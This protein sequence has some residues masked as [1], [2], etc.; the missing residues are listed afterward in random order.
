MSSTVDNRIV[1]MQFDNAQFES[2]VKTTL[3]TLE[4][5]KEKM[6]FDEATE[7]LK[8]LEKATNTIDLNGL[9]NA[10][11][12]VTDRFSVF[13]EFIHRKMQDILDGVVSSVKNTLNSVTFEPM[14]KGWDKYEQKLASVQ[15]I[16]SALRD[17]SEGTIEYVSEQVE[18][19]NW[20]TDET[21]YSFTDMINTI[22]KFTSNGISLAD[23]VSAL[24]GVS[25]AAAAAGANVSSAS[26]AME[27]FAK[28]I[29][30]GYMSL[31]T[32]SFIKTAHMDTKQFKEQL[33]ETAAAMGTLV[34]TSDGLYKTLKGEEVSFN[35]FEAQLTKAKWLTKEVL[36]ETL[37]NYGDFAVALEAAM[38]EMSDDAT[39]T[40][41]LGFIDRFIEGEDVAAEAA[42]VLGI[43]TDKAVEALT[44][45]SSEQFKVGRNAF[46]AA[47]EAKTFTDA[48]K[49][50][51]DATSTGWMKTW[52]LIFG[53]YEES[54]K[55]W[56]DL[57]NDL[58][59][60]FMPGINARNKLLTDWHAEEGPGSYADFVQGL[61][62]IF[63]GFA[64]LADRVR[65][66]FNKLIPPATVQDIK[67]LVIAFKSMTDGFLGWATGV[68]KV[69]DEVNDTFDGI[70][71]K[72]EGTAEVVT[73]T[74][75]LI[76]E[77]AHKVWRG[78]FGNG[79]ETRR[80][81]LE[82]LGYSFELV[83]NRVNELLGSS[84][85]YDVT[86]KK[87]V[88]TEEKLADVE[89][90][91]AEA[92]GEHAVEAA[93]VAESAEAAEEA[94][95]NHVSVLGKLIG[96]LG[97]IS[98]AIGII[99]STVG[100]LFN[101]V[102]A[103][104]FTYLIPKVLEG[105]LDLL[106]GVATKITEL[107]QQLDANNAF[108][109]FFRGIYDW[110]VKTKDMFEEAFDIVKESEALQTFMQHM[111]D[112]VD[113]MS[114]IGSSALSGV[115]NFFETLF[116]TANAASGGNP[117]AT[118]TIFIIDNINKFIEWIG[119]AMTTLKTMFVNFF[120]F[121]GGLDWNTIVAAF[122]PILGGLQQFWNFAKDIWAI[123]ENQLKMTNHVFRAFKTFDNPLGGTLFAL[124]MGKDGMKQYNT[125]NRAVSFV[126]NEVSQTVTVFDKIKMAIGSFVEKIKGYASTVKTAFQPVID[127]FQPVIDI[128]KKIMEKVSV[129][130]S[131]ITFKDIQTLIVLIGQIVLIFGMFK[132]LSAA[133][134]FVL[135]AS[136]IL[137][138]VK[139]AVER[140]SKGISYMFKS[141]GGA[142]EAARDYLK[143]KTATSVI[144][145]L[146]A[147]IGVMA[148]AV[149]MLS[150]IPQNDLVKA[151]I[152]VGAMAAVSI[153]M[154]WALGK[155]GSL[156]TLGVGAAAIFIGALAA[157]IAV[158]V[159][160][161]KKIEELTRNGKDAER[162]FGGLIGILAIVAIF[163]ATMETWSKS[164]TPQQALAMTTTMISLY[165]FAS[166]V[167]KL[168]AALKEIADMKP[169]SLGPALL[170]L[171]GVVVLLGALAWA[172]SKLTFGAGAGLIGVVLAIRLFLTTLKSIDK[173]NLDD[174]KGTIGKLV[175][176]MLAMLGLAW[177]ASKAGT[178]SVGFAA[179]IA[180][181]AL[182]MKS[183]SDLI[184]VLDTVPTS[185]VEK[186]VIVIV[187][188][189]GMVSILAN[190][191]SK[192]PTV[193][194]GGKTAGLG[195]TLF[196]LAFALI[197]VAAAL[198][199][200]S[201][202]PAGSLVLATACISVIIGMIAV[203]AKLSSGVQK[204]HIAVFGVA[205]LL[206]VLTGL[207]WVV[208][209][210]P[211]ENAIVAC[212]GVSAVLLSLGLM[213]RNVSSY[214]PMSQ[215]AKAKAIIVGMAAILV[216]VA[217]SIGALA[218]FFDADEIA[219]IALGM[220]FLITSLGVAFRMIQTEHIDPKKLLP[221][222]LEITM[223]MAAI[224]GVI[225]LVSQYTTGLEA[226]EIAAALSIGMLSVAGSMALIGLIPPTVFTKATLTVA[227]I[228]AVLAAIVGALMY[229]GSQVG[230]GNK[231]KS[232]IEGMKQLTEAFEIAGNMIG[233]FLGSIVG[234]F[235]F[236]VAVEAEA[237]AK[238]LVKFVNAF[239]EID[240]TGHVFDKIESVGTC[241]SA[242]SAAS[243]GDINID[244]LSTNLV[245][246]GTAVGGFVDAVKDI[247][248]D[249][250]KQAI[251]DAFELM[252]ELG[253]MLQKD[254]F[255]NSGMLGK[256]FGEHSWSTVSDG[257]A[258]F[259]KA[260]TQF[261][262]SV[263]S[264]VV[265]KDRIKIATELGQGLAE[266]L[267]T[268]PEPSILEHLFGVDSW[269]AISGGL[270]EF[271]NALKDFCTVTAGI[272]QY[273]GNMDDIKTIV[274]AI[275]AMRNE[276]TAG[277][278]E[279]TL[280][281]KI[282]DNE[283]SWADIAT[284]LS[285]FGIA[286]S[287]F[288]L[289]TAGIEQYAGNMEGIKTIVSAIIDMKQY[290]DDDG[291]TWLER[292]YSGKSGLD[293]DDIG[294]GLGTFGESIAAFI[295]SLNGVNA[296]NAIPIVNSIK[297]LF[298]ATN[299]LFASGFEARYFS[300]L[301]SYL[302][303]FA[304]SMVNFQNNMGIVSTYDVDKVTYI[305]GQIS[306]ICGL[307]D[308]PSVIKTIGE[309]VKTFG[310][311]IRD[312]YDNLA[313]VTDQ[314]TVFGMI[315][316]DIKNLTEALNGMDFTVF[317]QL[318]SNLVSNVVNGMLYQTGAGADEFGGYSAG[319]SV[320]PLT[321]A[322]QTL[323]DNLH[324][325]VEQNL[326]PFK[327]DGKKFITATSEGVSADTSK[328][329]LNNAAW[330]TIKAC[331][332]FLTNGDHSAIEEFRK[333]GVQMVEGLAEGLRDK[334]AVAD[335]VSAATDLAGAVIKAAREAADSHSPS[336]KMISLGHDMDGGL[337]VGIRGMMKDVEAV[338]SELGNVACNSV[339]A[340][341]SHMSNE[342]GMGLLNDEYPSITPV[343]DLSQTYSG[344][345]DLSRALGSSALSTAANI[346]VDIK[347]DIQDLVYIG[348]KLLSAI[349][350]GNDLYLDENVLVGRINRRLGQI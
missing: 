116:A 44:S 60:I 118:F 24:M 75:E 185:A 151:G 243:S 276:L 34:K 93:A 260:M 41:V 178:A 219:A 335:A 107:K 139:E 65:K 242:L 6:N 169:E 318:G 141:I 223:V 69:K 273:A 190:A 117:V 56:T 319:A 10:M 20:Y 55:M 336:R 275:I 179:T 349:Q 119:P 180:A 316:E 333:L 261:G 340:A 63:D 302:D 122:Q 251:S 73:M 111:S 234:G 188:L 137:V 131:G 269:Q 91:V 292:W 300:S 348:N 326:N 68:E 96:I 45:L 29:G 209:I 239:A 247:N 274:S 283:T 317:M 61:T 338:G 237:T 224:G 167:V 21:S 133:S 215:L 168:V 194:K 252:D 155:L 245:G 211:I 136:K 22:S 5:L 238:E 9:N 35:N 32:W 293:W 135:E 312:L 23:S 161:L 278:D 17:T 220:T 88:K 229:A 89:G 299:E 67:N 248:V 150:S 347:D 19:L 294:N 163:V 240:D 307:F 303:S 206:L 90:E 98:S 130:V 38:A 329:T 25:S 113:H 189:I 183:I 101:Y 253:T 26:H 207:L 271:G 184:V 3:K 148:A 210:M 103:P 157:T 304:A 144:W 134:V 154:V 280:L 334:V 97:G 332:E 82:K 106:Y 186:G 78:D 42:E 195:G 171:V 198:L 58:Y 84:F 108:E 104:I 14:S 289:N 330:E 166:S 325:Y 51:Q 121:L 160:S 213:L 287:G 218:Y 182:V 230:D 249:G 86:E 296:S 203:F 205:A 192:M 74:A 174:V 225:A 246:M 71:D 187:A 81:A 7:S 129:L 343:L 100:A 291:K 77:L 202:I 62:N 140:I 284:G 263:I 109:V 57:A 72:V 156:N 217:G 159:T 259:G 337:I 76:D 31:N 165:V 2:G 208:S 164:L 193:A 85:R 54:K 47:Q 227:G 197:A 92:M 176:I 258:E 268:V 112:F 39:A 301:G 345:R 127:F 146:V 266:L 66:A 43:T 254:I 191:M 279:K 228:A 265:H 27:G 87:I 257:L 314:S 177:I 70:S 64:A 331:V 236:G 288:C 99:K 33:I 132:V 15:T 115:T 315:T 297:T 305:M 322:M 80:A 105:I 170:G 320:N 231:L 344:A 79:V 256:V 290:L 18:K 221:I 125:I 214:M 342:L 173:F 95:E 306:E 94:T 286:L 235:A 52:E 264:A 143:A 310:K 83:Q 102:V 328:T 37:K 46:K 270:K 222:I 53:N 158:F 324:K 244:E 8:N 226:L 162:A 201:K 142:F 123:I 272:E 323:L 128:V 48:I 28:A 327:E 11:K 59:D 196:G 30:Q 49:S 241:L 255:K 285:Q 12:T 346:S 199:I 153:G 16:M 308:D 172:S 282:F 204:A 339:T 321:V 114:Q 50:V 152:A 138:S 262:V 40:K 126:E 212:A 1:K 350:N 295:N 124:I 216:L 4:S 313:G 175:L 277:D 200:M 298:G 281:N 120:T 233:V 36:N 181:L 110:L 145:A 309:N 341:V 149:Y 13:G 232:T 311:G 147:L 250:N 267:A